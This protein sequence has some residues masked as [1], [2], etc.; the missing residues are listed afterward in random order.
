M[1][2]LFAYMYLRIHSV[3][4]I[5]F[6]SL[7]RME[8]SDPKLG[9]SHETGTHRN[10]MWSMSKSTL[11]VKKFTSK[12]SQNHKGLPKLSKRAVRWLSG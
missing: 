2:R 10:T 9:R 3:N 5:S 6:P 12:N 7:F 8:A 1:R 4:L 11:T